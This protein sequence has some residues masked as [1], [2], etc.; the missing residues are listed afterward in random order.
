MSHSSSPL[1]ASWHLGG[2]QPSIVISWVTTTSLANNLLPHILHLD[3]PCGSSLR[4]GQYTW[5]TVTDGSPFSVK[6]RTTH[7]RNF[8]PTN[9]KFSTGFSIHGMNYRFPAKPIER[10][11]ITLR[12]LSMVDIISRYSRDGKKTRDRTRTRVLS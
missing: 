9:F 4:R 2:L 7:N 12:Q 3:T 8:V 11:S 1:A 5:P 6:L 10:T